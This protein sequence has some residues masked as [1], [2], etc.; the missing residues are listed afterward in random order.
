MCDNYKVERREEK[1]EY[2]G[3]FK[4]LNKP[5]EKNDFTVVYTSKEV[6]QGMEAM[7]KLEVPGLRGE[8]IKEV[9]DY[10]ESKNCLSFPFGGCV[11][12]QF[13]GALPGDLDMETN[14]KREYF[15]EVCVAW[16][17]EQN[18]QSGTTAEHIGSKA[19]HNDLGNT[20]EL[21]AANWK[22]TFFGD[23]TILEYTTNSIAYFANGKDIVIDLTGSGVYDTCKKLIRIPVAEHLRNAWKSESKT[24]RYWK[25]RAKGY[26][27]ADEGTLNFIVLDMIKNQPKVF[28]KYYCK[29]VLQGEMS[30]TCVILPTKCDLPKKDIFDDVFFE[31]LKVDWALIGQDLTHRME[32]DSCPNAPGC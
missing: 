18:C 6:T 20:D 3:E 13:L 16:W 10:L 21:D 9:L 14:C 8:K 5:W 4:G 19:D 28:K 24:F 22:E 27:A 2:P 23:G 1:L 30:N 12:D 25:L 17:G 7:F 31:D 11:R 29:Y 32:C 26:K 15:K